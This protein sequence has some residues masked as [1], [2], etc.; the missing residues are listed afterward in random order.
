MRL[1]IKVGLNQSRTWPTIT[2]SVHNQYIKRKKWHQHGIKT[3][4][5]QLYTWPPR[6]VGSPLTPEPPTIAATALKWR[7]FFAKMGVQTPNLRYWFRDP[8]KGTSLGGTASFDVFCVKIGARVSAVI[9]HGGRYH[10]RSHLHKFWWPSVEGFLGG[11]GQISS[12]PINFDRHP[13]NT[14]ALLC[15]CVIREQEVPC[16]NCATCELKIAVPHFV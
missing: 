2:V 6:K 16:C 12:F 4:G 10:R 11:G 13:Y 8:P 5:S 14:L 7:F 1:R 15:E 9:L 3:V